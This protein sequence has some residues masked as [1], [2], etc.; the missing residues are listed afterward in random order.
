VFL[1]VQRPSGYDEAGLAGYG[2]A[3][4]GYGAGSAAY[5]DLAQIPGQIT[6]QVIQTTISRLLP[7]NTTAWLRIN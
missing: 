7:V 1:T 6:D 3:A 2:T 5:L 4:G